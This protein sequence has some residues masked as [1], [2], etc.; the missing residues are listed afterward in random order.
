M[1]HCPHRI[2]VCVDVVLLREHHILEK[3]ILCEFEFKL[4]TPGILQ[5]LTAD[6]AQVSDKRRSE[7]RNEGREWL[8]Q[9]LGILLSHNHGVASKRAVHQ[10]LEPEIFDAC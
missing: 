5:Q 9:R 4:E 6:I 3:R 10:H 7:G 1:P 2:A 8:P